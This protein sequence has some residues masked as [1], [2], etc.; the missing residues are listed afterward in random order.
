MPRKT[1][2]KLQE[3][4]T[5]SIATQS[6]LRSV[7]I[8][9]YFPDLN[10]SCTMFAFCGALALTEV[11]RIPAKVYAGSFF[12]RQPKSEI[13]LSYAEKDTIVGDDTRQG[14][15]AW[16]ETETHIIDF[17]SPLYPAILEAH[18]DNTQKLKFEN[19]ML[20]IRL[21]DDAQSWREFEDGK[22][23]FALATKNRTQYIASRIFST[24][25]LKD[26]ASLTSQWVDKLR[27]K[28]GVEM[29][30]CDNYGRH[31]RLKP[32]GLASKGAWPTS[33]G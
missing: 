21:Q 15:H 9:E 33:M 18:P 25:A 2:L 20:Q 3:F 1:H 27:K 30:I 5:I 29:D 28:P 12:V 22:S 31:T 32:H 19:R 16:V 7:A 11:Y 17:M 4:N 26:I 23:I 24:P 13:V 6:V 14:F 8:P 10:R